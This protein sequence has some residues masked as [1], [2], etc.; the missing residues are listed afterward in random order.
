[1]S[2]VRFIVEE[3]KFVDLINEKVRLFKSDRDATFKSQSRLLAR[4]LISRTPPFKGKELVKLLR[5]GSSLSDPAIANLSAKAI[6]ERAILRE[7]RAIFLPVS[8]PVFNR[9]VKY[10]QGKRNLNSPIRFIFSG[11]AVPEVKF[12]PQPD[13]EWMKKVRGKYGDKP[14]SRKDDVRGKLTVISKYPVPQQVFNK[15]V[16]AKQ[17]MVGQARGGWAEGFVRLGG[18]VSPGNWVGRHLRAG[19]GVNIF[20]DGK[21]EITFNNRSEW[22]SAGDPD[23]II[24]ASIAGRARAITADLQRKLQRDLK[25]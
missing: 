17:K 22:A 16:K 13:T 8:A 1:M 4:E 10:A 21:I 20:S 3:K 19:H 11:H 5:E 6:G 7:A 18:K 24:S 12:N 14:K 25:K 9:A 23:R 2:G 15:F